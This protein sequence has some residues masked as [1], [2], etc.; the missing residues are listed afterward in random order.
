M[1]SSSLHVPAATRTSKGARAPRSL[2]R[3]SSGAVAVEYLVVFA[4]VGLT[5]ALA[6]AAAAPA[7]ARHYADQRA[8]L[9]Q[10]NP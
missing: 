10:P 2:L 4:F 1:S 6:I 3:D 9:Y 5:T 7:I 8:I